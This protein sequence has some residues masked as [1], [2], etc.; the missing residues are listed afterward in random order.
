MERLDLLRL[1]KSA[2]MSQRELA[3]A[4]GV[5][6]SFLSAIENGKSRLPDEKIERLK[7]LFDKDD[8]SEF[9]VDDAEINSNIVPPHSHAVDETDSITRLLQHIHAQAHKGDHERHNR[10]TELQ[11][12]IDALSERN[13]RLSCR[14]DELRD[15]IDRLNSE[16]L[17]LMS[18]LVKNNI[19]IPF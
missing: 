17:T 1:R 16:K 19:D 9:Y 18:L 12:R 6:P 15:E 11:K 2:G 14:L 13:D 10:E 8:L 4:L 7:I 5:R 3:E